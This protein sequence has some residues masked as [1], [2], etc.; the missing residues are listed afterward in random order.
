MELVII[1]INY[2]VLKAVS[3]YIHQNRQDLINARACGA[4]APA[5]HFN[6]PAREKSG[7]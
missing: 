3:V 5:P 4:V 2:S 1:K 6:G 7:F